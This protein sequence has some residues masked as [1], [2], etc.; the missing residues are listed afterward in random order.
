[1]LEEHLDDPPPAIVCAGADSSF[2]DCVTAWLSSN[3]GCLH[4]YQNNGINYADDD[5]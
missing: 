3:S 5:C 2:G 1:M 4:L